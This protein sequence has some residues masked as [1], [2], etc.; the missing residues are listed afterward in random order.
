[1]IQVCILSSHHGQF[2]PDKK[3][4]L[5]L[6]GSCELVRPTIA[7]RILTYRGEGGEL[8]RPNTRVLFLTL[9]GSTR[10]TAPTL[11]AEFLDL[12]EM[13]SGG[14][15]SLDEFDILMVKMSRSNSSTASVT[16]LSSFADHELPSETEEIN[17]LA[18]QRHLGN[19]P[20]E[21]GH[22]LQLGIGQPEVE[23]HATVKR[24]IL[25]DT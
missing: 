3:L 4:F 20:E 23:R 6:L 16:L 22:I 24:A 9:L 18:L 13:I 25:A 14:T 19:I 2:R 17:S 21:A 7:R 10:L 5:T 12:R 1:M 8:I 15:L 11:A